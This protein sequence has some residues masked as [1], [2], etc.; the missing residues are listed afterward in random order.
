MSL[1]ALFAAIGLAAVWVAVLA[2]SH[3]TESVA[4]SEP[5]WMLGAE[6]LYPPERFRVHDDSR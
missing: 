1:A 4:D 3:W 5:A 2:W 6:S